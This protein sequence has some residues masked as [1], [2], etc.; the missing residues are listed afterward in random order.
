MKKYVIRNY[1]DQSKVNYYALIMSW[2]HVCYSQLSINNGNVHKASVLSD[3]IVHLYNSLL[4][5]PLIGIQPYYTCWR[6][7][8]YLINYLSSNLDAIIITVLPARYIKTW[9]RNATQVCNRQ[10][11]GSSHTKTSAL[12]HNNNNNNNNKNHDDY[13]Y[14][15]KTKM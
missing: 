4:Y 15:A 6:T 8:S 1:Y 9:H 14:K 11:Q 2:N 10:T 5:H 7:W 3:S 12:T 13:S